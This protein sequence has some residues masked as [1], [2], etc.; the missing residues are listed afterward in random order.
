M[1]AAL[2]TV[3][4]FKQGLVGG[5]WEALAPATGD[6]ATFFNVP[7]GSGPFLGE[8]WANNDANPC[9]ISLTASRFHDQTF[10]IRAAVPDG[11]LVAPTDRMVNVSPIGFDQPVYPSDVL[12]VQVN[13][14]AADNVNVTLQL[15]Y[16]DLPGIAGRFLSSQEV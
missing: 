3:T 11:D 12:T 13:G 15:Y 16:P 7:S 4:F 5:A 9:E 2:Q 8:I 10:G 6:S 14:I 1:P